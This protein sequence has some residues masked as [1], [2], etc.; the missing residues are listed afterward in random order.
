VG[1]YSD[2]MTRLAREPKTS[3]RPADDRPDTAMLRDHAVLNALVPVPSVPDVPAAV[4]Q[5]DALRS[6]SERLAPMAIVDST[7]RLAVA[8]CRP[9]DGVSTV[10]IALAMD[11]SQRLSLKT[12]LVDA[13]IRHPSLHRFF[14]MPQA[15]AQELLLEGALQIRASGRAR[16]DLA[17][18][19]LSDGDEDREEVLQDFEELLPRYEAAVLDLGVPR[20]DA[21]MLPLARTADPIL[22]V[23]KYGETERKELLTTSTALRA[24]NRS[25]AG[26]ILNSKIDPVAKPIRS[27][28][29]S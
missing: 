14:R 13:H 18:C 20:L 7:I 12:I 25:I 9:G 23:V 27:F 3:T 10:A 19:C 2:T 26:V 16:L 4:S 1:K 11:L 8:G 29:I 5:C 24:A 22:L 21:R 6:I 15:R 17:S 28:L